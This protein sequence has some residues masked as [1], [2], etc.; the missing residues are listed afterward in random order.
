MTEISI[1]RRRTGWDVVMG[2][3]AVLAGLVVFGNVV[4]AT[5]V[6]VLFIG[7]FAVIGGLATLV[8]A[9]LRIGKGGFWPIAIGGGLLLVLG[10]MF[11]RRPGV[12]ALALTLLAG[13][14]FLAGGITRL[15]GAAQV[16]A[17]RVPLLFSGAVS[18]ILGLII[19]FDIWDATLTLLGILLGVELL[20]EGITLLLFGRLHLDVRSEDRPPVSA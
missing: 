3:L 10:L 1:G 16:P 18:T 2:V 15:V 4:L 13:A 5:T 6:S 19:F 12:G 9:F 20:T 8:G 11:V 14:L 17:A 7:W